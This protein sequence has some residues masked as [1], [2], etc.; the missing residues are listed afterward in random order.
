MSAPRGHLRRGGFL[1]TMTTLYAAPP[2]TAPPTAPPIAPPPLSP[3]DLD[4]DADIR[5]VGSSTQVFMDSE[6]EEEQEDVQIDQV[7]QAPSSPTP[8]QIYGPEDDGAE[9]QAV[10]AD[11]TPP[12]AHSLTYQLPGNQELVGSLN[13]LAAFAKQWLPNTLALAIGSDNQP[14]V[15]HA[16]QVEF[17]HL[18]SFVLELENRSA[19][20]GLTPDYSVVGP[21]DSVWA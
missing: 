12:A 3:A 10:E 21:W 18:Y 7:W 8:T 16:L 1:Y 2:P 9:E 19:A 13:T 15:R 14:E 11:V 5:S 20:A 17:N 4:L 6:D